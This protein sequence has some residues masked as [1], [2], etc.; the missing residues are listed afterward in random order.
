MVVRHRNHL[1]VRSA[2]TIAANSSPT[3]YDFTTA[4][5]QAF[6][7]G[8]ISNAAMASK[9]LPGNTP[10]VFLLWAGN[11]NSD[12]AVRAGGGPTLSDYLT[13]MSSTAL[14]GDFTKII[15]SVYRKEDLNMDG[16]LRAGGGPTLSDYLTLL[17]A[18][19]L[20]GSFTAIINS[21]L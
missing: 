1:S 9:D 21:H 14:Q 4:Q 5:S 18:G 13:I 10:G 3:L 19:V 17:S 16:V 20:D 2:T 7:N 12:N 6:Q 11:A 15:T 8:A